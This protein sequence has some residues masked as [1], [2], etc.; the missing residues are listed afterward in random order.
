MSLFI[1]PYDE[2]LPGLSS[3]INWFYISQSPQERGH[4]K[5]LVYDLIEDQSLPEEESSLWVSLFETSICP[6][7]LQNILLNLDFT[8][9]TCIYFI[10]VTLAQIGETF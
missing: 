10:H 6:C 9:L 4:P 2:R 7:H 8:Y 3:V 5:R 1:G